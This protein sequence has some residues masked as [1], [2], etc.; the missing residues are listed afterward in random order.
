[1]GDEQRQAL[2]RMFAE[3]EAFKA[4]IMGATSVEDAVT[5]AREYGVEATADDLAPAQGA[6]SDA[7]LEDAAGG[8]PTLT[9]ICIYSFTCTAVGC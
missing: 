8:S 1:M 9:F 3:D 6:L 7:E 5:I 2:T 4:A